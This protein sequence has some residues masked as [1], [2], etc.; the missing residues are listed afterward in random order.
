MGYFFFRQ[1]QDANIRIPPFN[2]PLVINIG[3]K[4]KKNKQTLSITKEFM[5]VLFVCLLYIYIYTHERNIPERIFHK[6]GTLYYI[7]DSR[8]ID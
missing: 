4:K 1:K 3:P 6:P 7:K 8:E 2:F 5:I